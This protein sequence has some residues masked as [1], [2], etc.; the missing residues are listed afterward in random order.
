[1]KNEGKWIVIRDIHED[2]KRTSNVLIFTMDV[3]YI[4]MGIV[5]KLSIAVLVFI[6]TYE[7]V[8]CS[9]LIAIR[10]NE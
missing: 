7:N 2:V 8:K 1:M 5:V 9:S 4:R 10:G 3:E 6:H